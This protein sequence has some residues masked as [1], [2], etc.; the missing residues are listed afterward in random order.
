MFPVSTMAQAHVSEPRSPQLAMVESK[1]QRPEKQRT[2]TAKY[3]NEFAASRPCAV[4]DY[5]HH[6]MTGRFKILTTAL[7]EVH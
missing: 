3:D 6:R 2:C 4:S 1:C 7:Q 5:I